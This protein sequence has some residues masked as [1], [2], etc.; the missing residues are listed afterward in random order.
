MNTSPRP[1]WQSCW[2]TAAWTGTAASAPPT[3][4]PPGRLTPGRVA[5]APS[6][7]QFHRW[8]TGG[9]R[10]LPYTDHCRVL[11]HMLTGYSAAQ[12]LQPCPYSRHSRA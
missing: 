2:K 3:R 7:A 1:C 12:L 5:A 8:T 9:L 11:E 6:R 4:K 10:G